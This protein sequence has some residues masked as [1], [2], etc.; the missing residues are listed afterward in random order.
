MTVKN[1]G[2]LLQFLSAGDANI[3]SCK[4]YFSPKQSGEGTPSPENVRPIE[5]WSGVEVTHCGKNLLPDNGWN[6]GYYLNAKGVMKESDLLKISPYLSLLPDIYHFSGTNGSKE[7]ITTSFHAYDENK[8]W[9]RRFAYVTANPSETYDFT[10]TIPNDAKYIAIS[11][12]NE[13]INGQLEIGEI[14]TSFE[15]YQSRVEKELPS[16][17]QRVEYIESTGTQYFWT[18][19]N[20]QDGLTVESAS[21]YSLYQDSYLF[22]GAASAANDRVCF[23]GVY[24]GNLQCA[25]PSGWFY[26]GTIQQDGKTIERITTT[27]SNNKVTIY[28][29]GD[30]VTNQ[31]RSGTLP[32][33]TGAKC[34]C[35]GYRNSYG[36]VACFYKGKVYEL[37]IK[38]GTDM[39]AN[40][41]PCLRR[42]D[43]K[44]GMYDTVSQTFYTNQ[45]TGEFIAGPAVNRYEIDW[46]EDLGTIY[47][48]YV[49]LVSG[50]LVEEF[51]KVTLDGSFSP[52]IFPW[53][54]EVVEDDTGETLVKALYLKRNTAQSW[55]NRN[56]YLTAVCDKLPCM[57]NYNIKQRS[58]SFYDGDSYSICLALPKSLVGTTATELNQYLSENPITTSF[59]LNVP[60]THQLS[61]AILTTL[62][63]QNTFWSNADYIEIEYDLIETQ[64]I[65]DVRKR[66]IGSFPHL[67]TA[68]G[69][70]STDI[71]APLKSCRISFSPIQEG[72]GDPSPSNVRP[73]K[74][75]DGIRIKNYGRNMANPFLFKEDKFIQA[76]GS[77]ANLNGFMYTGLIPVVSPN[78]YTYS[79]TNTYGAINI[80]I[81]GYDVD[82]KWLKQ[83]QLD[84]GGSRNT[85]YSHQINISEDN[86]KFIRISTAKCEDFQVELGD[87]ATD[88]DNGVEITIPFPQTI[89]GGYVDLV[90]GEIVETYEKKV[91]DGSENWYLNVWS[92]NGICF[93]NREVSYQSRIIPFK[94]STADEIKN[95]MFKSVSSTYFLR[96]DGI[97]SIIGGDFLPAF[98]YLLLYNSA[99]GQTVDEYK[100]VL[101]NLYDNGTPVEIVA[102]LKTAYQQ[103]YSF[104][105]SQ[106]K[107]LRG[108]NNVFSDANGSVELTYWTH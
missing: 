95:N 44:P 96:E 84:D 94:S 43:S 65:M 100:A 66:I 88:Y 56:I 62:T 13:L 92:N 52:G 20:V 25:Y 63:G 107:T 104:T 6:N 31:T 24:S 7:I 57:S 17:Y 91:L 18:D 35:F 78:V 21:T 85:R 86:I 23:N 5:G 93:S 101:K 97:C 4:V 30:L 42:S 103:R 8:Q 70:F 90:K 14:T 16:E 36:N 82:G 27:L 58:C 11:T 73:I 71:A 106:I 83:I 50:E 48:G 59:K 28:K 76:G 37:R 26:A 54:S 77:V 2:E 34:V 87:M 64:E 105:P 108:L 32:K 74:G 29:N 39:L 9:L 53:Q 98:T 72:E 68:G 33:E 67:E 19:I 15:S 40:F 99:W 61:P 102:P 47:G 41:I 79:G 46:S 1:Q 60:I 45:G 12:V 81:H 75:W 89:Y 55:K 80:R 3:S 10:F 51:A 38:K 69:Q 49:D 22:G